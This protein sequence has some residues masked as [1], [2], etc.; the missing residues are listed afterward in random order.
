MCSGRRKQ[1]LGACWR[2][3]AKRSAQL[4]AD[5]GSGWETDADRHPPC[6]PTAGGLLGLGRRAEAP[7][8][9][10]QVPLLELNVG[11]NVEIFELRI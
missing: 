3:G 11:R 5:P 2:S 8:N 10:R 9:S 4:T 7:E 6:R 1:Q